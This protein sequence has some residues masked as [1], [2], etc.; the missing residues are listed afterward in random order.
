MKCDEAVCVV[1]LPSS[2]LVLLPWFKEFAPVSSLGFATRRK[3]G[4]YTVELPRG[5]VV[6]VVRR[7][8]GRKSVEY[9]LVDGGLVRLVGKRAKILGMNVWG[10]HY[11]RS[12]NGE[13]VVT[14]VSI[15]GRL[16]TIP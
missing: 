16:R 4:V 7:S 2:T 12:D 15:G 10:C 5:S 14:V 6:R 1:T 9:Y 11:F 8:S 13:K 3:G